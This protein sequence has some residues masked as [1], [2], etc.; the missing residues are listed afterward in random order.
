MQEEQTTSTE[1]KSANSKTSPT[2]KE[3]EDNRGREAQQEDAESQTSRHEPQLQEAPG[4]KRKNTPPAQTA[5]PGEPHRAKA[6][7]A[8]QVR[9]Q[10][11]EH[12]PETRTTHPYPKDEDRKKA[13]RQGAPGRKTP[14]AQRTPKDRKTKTPAPSLSP[15]LIQH[16]P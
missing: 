14:K 6:S 15:T 8:A 11:K 5:K 13:P 3:K 2:I 10:G 9:Q 4:P 12:A 1:R 7:P 16:T